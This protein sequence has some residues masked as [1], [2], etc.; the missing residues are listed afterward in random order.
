MA[1]QIATN[2][3]MC[4]VQRA[5]K[6]YT[7]PT[8]IQPSSYIIHPDS[9]FISNKQITLDT[10]E[11]FQI[12]AAASDYTTTELP[13]DH[14]IP[15]GFLEYTKIDVLEED[16]T[17]RLPVSCNET[18]IVKD[19]NILLYLN[20]QIDQTSKYLL[21]VNDIVEVDQMVIVKEI[22][23]EQ[24]RYH[25]K[26]INRNKKH[27]AVGLWME[28]N[29]TYLHKG[30]KI[31]YDLRNVVEK[32]SDETKPIN[33]VSKVRMMSDDGIQTYDL[34]GPID[35]ITGNGSLKMAGESIAA[36]VEKK[37]SQAGVDKNE[38][39]NAV[40]SDGIDTTASEEQA[41]TITG[42]EGEEGYR[43]LYE[44]YGMTYYGDSLTGIPIGRMVFVHGMPFQYTYITDRRLNDSAVYGKESLTEG[45]VKSGNYD[46]Y[47]RD[48]A[49]NIAGN[50]PIATM[51]PGVPVFLTNIKQSIL[52]STAV[53][54]SD[55]QAG[56]LPIFS[57][58]SDNQLSDALDTMMNDNSGE[59]YQY[60]SME[61]DTTEYFNF[62]NALCGTVAKFMGIGGESYRGESLGNFD[63]GKFN[64]SVSQD[65]SMFEEIAGLNNG[66][67]FA[68]DP[69]SSVTDSMSNSTGE[70]EFA[71]LFNGVSSKAR[72][73]EFM[74]GSTAFMDGNLDIINSEEYTASLAELG[75]G[76]TSG[77]TNP[78][79]VVTTLLKNA[80]HGMNVR[81]PLI[82][83]DNS[84]TKSYDID[85]RFIT[86]YATQFCKFRY[87]IVPFLHLFTFA[88]P[89]SKDT[90]INYSRPFLIKA[91]SRGYFN[92]EMGMI[93]TL[94]WK[95]F[96]DGDMISTDGV[97][98]QIDVSVSFQD[99]YQQVGISMFNGETTASVSRIAIF[100]NNTGLMDLLGSLSGI[101]TNT[102]TLGERLSM[103]TSSAVGAF[104]NTGSNF[105]RHISD[106][107][108]NSTIVSYMF[109]GAS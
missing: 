2:C 70:S 41:V 96:G 29:P 86:P 98:T 19:E 46:M 90:V 58:L 8:D 105:M 67:S 55:A 52:G 11:L 25:I 93:D 49:E 43:G 36:D 74:V 35:M 37:L 89:Q 108:R 65:Y 24:P 87:V 57:D 62:V 50:M 17:E 59:I 23:M 30:Q 22:N 92:V 1:I 53:E 72:E 106:R 85:M 101:N 26:T 66:V 97:P 63:W 39:T 100:F 33:K 61:I 104:S 15:K 4:R 34:I 6:V 83:N 10:N 42:I 45:A 18:F 78:L 20:S 69:L 77:L 44:D 5:V 40:T 71:G 80:A 79:S 99:L 56:W 3:Y 47:G 9:I 21:S 82:W 73:L 109:G 14:W 64:Q 28:G 91:Y 68:F 38:I 7:N 51:L 31:R 81:F 103:L 12:T 75:D 94:Q 76:F 88:A 84:Y 54:D 13:F 48:F 95:R 60:Y 102:M 32:T 27:P 107:L 16:V